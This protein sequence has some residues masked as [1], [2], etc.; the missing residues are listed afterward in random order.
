VGSSPA[1]GAKV[2]KVANT[3][4]REYLYLLCQLDMRSEAAAFV[5]DV[6]SHLLGARYEYA[7]E[8]EAALPTERTVYSAEQLQ[9]RH[10]L[11][12]RLADSR[13]PLPV[14][15]FW[16]DSW[17]E[18]YAR[19]LKEIGNWQELLALYNLLYFSPA[20]SGKNKATSQALFLKYAP[21]SR[22]MMYHETCSALKAAEKYTLLAEFVSK[23]SLP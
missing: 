23:Q 14:R 11:L 21:L 20:G 6:Y 16:G 19:K 22:I 3:L 10:V 17:L 2:G 7:L 9:Q 8:S 5:S 13:P 15:G 12:Q 18:P 4:A 1:D